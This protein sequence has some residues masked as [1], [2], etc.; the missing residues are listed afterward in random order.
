MHAHD[1]PATRA[2]ALFSE[3][4][5]PDGVDR[6]YATAAGI[7]FE[8]KPSNDGTWHGYPIPWEHVPTDIRKRWLSKKS[9]LASQIK[10]YQ[11][12]AKDD[13]HWALQTD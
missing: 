7:A 12:F 6:R 10:K 5:P 1:W 11:S 8:A 3:A 13:I 9:V 2:A 4:E